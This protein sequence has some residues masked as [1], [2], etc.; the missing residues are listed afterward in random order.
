MIDILS[1]KLLLISEI[2]FCTIPFSAYADVPLS[3]FCE[4]IPNNIT[5]G[6]FKSEI[7]CTSFEI[8]DNGSLTISGID[9]TGFFSFNPSSTKIG[10]TKSF[11]DSLTS[12]TK[13]L[14]F[15]LIRSRLNLFEG[16]VAMTKI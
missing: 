16:N 1:P 9:P 13:F 2:A 15:G 3:S 14:I 4:G 6:I 12:C 5:A 10:H 11:T 8:S 7:F